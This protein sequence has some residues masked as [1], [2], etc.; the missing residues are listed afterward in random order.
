MRKLGFL[1]WLSV[2]PLVSGQLFIEQKSQGPR[3]PAELVAGFD[4]LG[5]GFT[6]PQGPSTGRNPSDNSIAVGPNHVVEIV[7]SRMAVYSKKGAIFPATG[8]VLYGASPTNTIFKGFGGR[9]EA[10]NNGD[11]VVRYDQ[12]ADR[13]L[14][15]MP[16][17]RRDPTNTVDPYSMCYAVSTGADPL[18][19]YHRY[20]FKRKLFPDY[21]RPAVWP[22][23]YYN[24]TST[25]DDVIQK[26]IC[27]ADRNKMLQGL[28]ATEQ[29]LII[30]GE[31]GRASCRERV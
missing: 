24:A 10:Q 12:L 7:N 29:C 19:P 28:P 13:W 23:G 20:E 3:P 30:D 8:K 26:H 2:A 21:P 14:Y 22:D 1:V 5:V 9:C 16:L 17:F 18:G 27:V 4:G 6:G 31:I 15:V 25:G 11:A